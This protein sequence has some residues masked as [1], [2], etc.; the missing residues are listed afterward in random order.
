MKFLSM[1]TIYYVNCTVRRFDQQVG[2]RAKEKYDIIILL[3]LL[4]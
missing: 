4:L 2:D 1:L 3:L